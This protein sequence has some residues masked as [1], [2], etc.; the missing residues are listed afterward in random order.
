MLWLSL[1]NKSQDFDFN[2]VTIK[3]TEIIEQIFLSFIILFFHVNC[4]D[5]AIIK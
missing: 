3:E 1:I 5:Q 2:F 4:D